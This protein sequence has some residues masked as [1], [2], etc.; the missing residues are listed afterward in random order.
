[1]LR[2]EK[3]VSVDLIKDRFDRMVSAVLVDFKG[4]DVE[5]VSKLRD[6]L[7]DVGVEYRVVKNT[8]TKLAIKDQDWAGDLAPAL[9]GMT[10]IAWS[11]E[12]PGAAAKVFSAFSKKNKHLKVKAGVIDGKVIDAQTVVSQ[13]A[14][15]PGKD[16][17][18]AKL[19][20]TFQAPAQQFV[21]QLSAAP[22]NFLYLLKAKQD[23]GEAA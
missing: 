12:E 6:Q 20:A 23:E 11:F 9:L 15:M 4:L 13:L 17:L 3:K 18:R 10:G 22:Q 14:T 21:Q 7:R 5:A 16:E 19:L 8:L 2:A 1:M